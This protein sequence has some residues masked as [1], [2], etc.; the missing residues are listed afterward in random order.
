M[1][2]Y[3]WGIW[4]LLFLSYEL[5]AAFNKPKG[6]T[7]SEVVGDWTGLRKWRREIRQWSLGRRTVLL[8]FLVSLTLH[9]VWG[10]TVIPVA[11]LGAIL[12]CVIAIG[13]FKEK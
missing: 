4:L 5:F 12:A 3:V 11:V 8:L 1:S 9:L 6:D 2:E 7:L 10:T 13:I